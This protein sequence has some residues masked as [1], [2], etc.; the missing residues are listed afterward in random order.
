MSYFSAEM[1]PCTF[2]R[3]LL[4]QRAPKP[5][6]QDK[7]TKSFKFETY[8][9]N[10]LSCRGKDASPVIRTLQKARHEWTKETSFEKTRPD[11]ATALLQE[12]FAAKLLLKSCWLAICFLQWPYS[13]AVYSY[14]ALQQILG[15][16]FWSLGSTRIWGPCSQVLAAV[17]LHSCC[18][19]PNFLWAWHALF[20]LQ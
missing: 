4:T 1:L 20:L 16:D 10:N 14:T 5:T 7:P 17:V 13:V 9:C 6:Q 18:G 11:I 3:I 2:P 15:M 19:I 12:K 8:Y